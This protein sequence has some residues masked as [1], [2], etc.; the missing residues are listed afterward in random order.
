MLDKNYELEYL[1]LENVRLQK[2]LTE[3]STG[4]SPNELMELLKLAADMR[5]LLERCRNLQMPM[6]LAKSVDG[7]LSRAREFDE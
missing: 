7:V 3:S 5:H 4:I 2:E 1:K 6:D